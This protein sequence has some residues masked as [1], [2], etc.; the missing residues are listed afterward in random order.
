MKKFA[1]FITLTFILAAALFAQQKFALVIGNGNY[2]SIGKLNNPVNDANDVSAVLQ[3]LG[4]NVDKV[5]DASLDQMESSIMRLKNR[6]SV[7]K[8]SYGFLF[9]AGHGVQS[10]GENYLIPV[11]ANIP[12]ENSLRDRAINVQWALAELNDAGNE[13][14]VI[15]LDACRDNPFSWKRSGNRGLSVVANQPADSIIVYATSAGSTA[16]DGNGRNGLFTSYLLNNLKT[17]DLAVDEIFKRTGADVARASNRTQ[18]P[19]IYSQYFDTAYFGNKPTAKAAVQPQQTTA[20]SVPQT[21]Q[22][23]QTTTQPVPQTTTQLPAVTASSGPGNGEVFKVDLS[24]LSILKVESGGDAEK[25]LKGNYSTLPGVKNEAPLTKAWS[26]VLIILPESA[27]PSD[28]SKYTRLTITAKYYDAAGTEIK[29]QNKQCMVSVIYDL[30]GNI[31]GPAENP[32]P[33][34][35]VKVF[36]VG[37]S[38]GRIHRDEGIKVTFKKTPQAVLLQNADKSKVAFIEMTSMVFHNGEYK[39]K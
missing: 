15:V 31:R 4:F 32:G 26:D 27:L 16:A 21:T 25:I 7:S 5:L 24:K 10:G 29:Q 6:L 19:A 28:L 14:N 36:D 38:E 1:V 33:N 20:Q 8:N 34:T 3:G 13:L 9:Y 2:T 23:Q 11:G 35:P 30:K 17:P 18:I 37:G 22:P 12:S 39:S